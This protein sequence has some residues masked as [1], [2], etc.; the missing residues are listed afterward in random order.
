[1]S[2]C[3]IEGCDRR[4]AGR[5]WCKMHWHRWRRH[6]DPTKVLVAGVDFNQKSPCSVEDCDRLAH[7][8]GF[9]MTHLTRWRKHGDPLFV[10]PIL[11]RPLVG[12]VPTFAAIHKRL[13]RKRG[14]AREYPC[15]DC[16]D[17]A[18][19]WSYMGGDPNELRGRSGRSVV[20]Y[21]LDLSLYAPRCVRCHRIFDASWVGRPRSASGSFLPSGVRGLS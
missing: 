9:C 14:S 18:A 16:G 13:S 12:E 19:E 4:R 20:P 11:G 3:V 5:G 2:T 21:S 15:V 7:A 10:A 8:H 17:R 1:M 6:G